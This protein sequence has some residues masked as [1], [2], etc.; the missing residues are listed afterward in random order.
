MDEISQRLQ[1]LTIQVADFD[2]QILAE[3]VKLEDRLAELTLVKSATAVA[4][5]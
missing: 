3:R 5:K 4:A 2:G 1:K